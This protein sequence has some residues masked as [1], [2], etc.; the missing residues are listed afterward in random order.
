MNSAQLVRWEADEDGIRARFWIDDARATHIGTAE[1]FLPLSTVIA[2][3]Q[4]MK[5]E[6]ERTNQYQLEF[7]S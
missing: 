5:A 2:F 6:Q 4:A 1:I 7:D 3:V